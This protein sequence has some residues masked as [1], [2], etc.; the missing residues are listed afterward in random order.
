M[1]WSEKA[2]R[3]SEFRSSTEVVESGKKSID[4]IMAPVQTQT[5]VEIEPNLT[6]E[7]PIIKQKVT[8]TSLPKFQF[9]I[10]LNI[11]F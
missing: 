2:S 5:V 3:E 9:E 6:I 1:F 4:I 11:I 7:K 8:P 10:K